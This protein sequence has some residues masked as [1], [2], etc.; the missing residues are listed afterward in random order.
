M[1]VDQDD[2][3]VIYEN[4]I[5]QYVGG[6]E[7]IVYLFRSKSPTLRENMNQAMTEYDDA[8]TPVEQDFILH[9]LEQRVIAASKK[10]PPPPNEQKKTASAPV[11]EQKKTPLT[12]SDEQKNRCSASTAPMR[13]PALSIPR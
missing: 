3:D 9:A 4:L 13:A 12:L 8:F 6:E 2:I 10:T 5:S 11:S 1:N 7:A